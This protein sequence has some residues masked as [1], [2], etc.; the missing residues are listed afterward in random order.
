MFALAPSLF[1]CFICFCCFHTPLGKHSNCLTE[2][3]KIIHQQFSWCPGLSASSTFFQHLPRVDGADGI[4]NEPGWLRKPTLVTFLLFY[5]WLH[6][7]TVSFPWNYRISVPLPPLPS[8][9][10]SPYSISDIVKDPVLHLLAYG[11]EFI[12]LY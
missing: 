7:V 1:Q 2:K 8:V 11:S 9:R 10:G 3:K 6:S 4:Y 5:W 12:L